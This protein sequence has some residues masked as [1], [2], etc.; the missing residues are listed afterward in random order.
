LP[1]KSFLIVSGLVLAGVILLILPASFFDDGPPLC[2]SVLLFD[3]ECYGCGLTRACQHLIHLQFK[4]AW[5]YNPLAF[6][7][8][9]VM[10]FGYFKELFENGKIIQSYYRNKSETP[11][12]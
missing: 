1:Y 11:V 10:G 7:A 2:L 4:E 5:S 3:M 6:A 12:S 9:P 8:L